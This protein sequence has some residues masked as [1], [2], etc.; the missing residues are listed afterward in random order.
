MRLLMLSVIAVLMGLLTV[1]VILRV[2]IATWRRTRYMLPKE[3]ARLRE[4]AKKRRISLI[5]R[6]F[7]AL[8][9]FHYEI[10]GNR[11]FQA[12][13]CIPLEGTLRLWA[14]PEQV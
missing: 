9:I 1:C 10:I 6:G 5:A 4:K 13:V 7:I 14:D 2:S 8:V 3:A 12:V 11:A